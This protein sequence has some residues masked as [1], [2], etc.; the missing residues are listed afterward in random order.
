ML[1]AGIAGVVVGLVLGLALGGGGEDTDSLS[2]VG[3]AR[4]SFRQAATV[5][6]I[7]P[8]EY[9]EGV[10]NGR[11]TSQPEYRGAVG[12]IAR[13]RALYGEGR[14]VL[15][16]VDAAQATALDHA[17]IRLSSAATERVPEGEVARQARRL[18]RALGGAI[19]G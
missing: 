5:L 15:A 19:D 14:P 2:G 4:S 10:E 12:A 16:Y 7:V 17:F 6:D 9:G 18:A 3:D 8:V 13:S 11:V 1:A